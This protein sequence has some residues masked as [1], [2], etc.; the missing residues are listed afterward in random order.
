MTHVGHT[1]SFD[2]QTNVE[3]KFYTKCEWR[4][5]EQRE[6]VFRK[7]LGSDPGRSTHVSGRSH[8]QSDSVFLLICDK[9]ACHDSFFRGKA[10][11]RLKLFFN[12]HL[13]AGSRMYAVSSTPTICLSDVMNCYIDK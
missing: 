4:I 6:C 9:L 12:N 8:G 10:S 11:R 3:F 5:S 7:R 2:K 13:V 1:G